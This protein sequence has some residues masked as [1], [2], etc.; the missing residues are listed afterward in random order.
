MTAVVDPAGHIVLA[1]PVAAELAVRESQRRAA[2]LWSVERLDVSSDRE[3]D[4]FDLLGRGCTNDEIARTLFV[5]PATVKTHVSNVLAKLRLP[6]RVHAAL[7]AHDLRVD[8][9][10]G[11][12]SACRR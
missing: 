12:R 7:L 8:D 10:E 9:A 1:P 5:S 6:N 11:D 3:R 2:H 4:V